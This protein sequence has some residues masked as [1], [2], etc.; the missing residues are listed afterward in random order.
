MKVFEAAFMG[1]LFTVCKTEE[2]EPYLCHQT[3]SDNILVNA[4]SFLTLLEAVTYQ[5]EN[6]QGFAADVDFG[7]LGLVEV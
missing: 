7:L 2:A 3:D 4:E 1:D 6:M 5:M